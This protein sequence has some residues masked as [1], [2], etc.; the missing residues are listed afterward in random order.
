MLSQPLGKCLTIRWLILYKHQDNQPNR[1]SKSTQNQFKEK[2]LVL[3]QMMSNWILLTSPLTN[4]I[5]SRGW[6][7][8]KWKKKVQSDPLTPDTMQ[9]RESHTIT[10]QTNQSYP[11]PYTNSHS[12]SCPHTKWSGSWCKLLMP[13]DMLEMRFPLSFFDLDNTLISNWPSRF[14][15]LAR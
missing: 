7:K 1:K 4:F 14:L 11:Y 9:L 10:N 13:T 2:I 8:I 5:A 6:K 15:L 3:N 12:N